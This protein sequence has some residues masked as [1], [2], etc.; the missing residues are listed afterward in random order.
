MLHTG[1]FANNAQSRGQNHWNNVESQEKP[2]DF[3]VSS[4]ILLAACIRPLTQIRLKLCLVS[5]N[6]L[7]IENG[8]IEEHADSAILSLKIEVRS[9]EFHE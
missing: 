2:G 7:E 8:F 9:Q 5:A 6:S 1:P 4:A 3:R